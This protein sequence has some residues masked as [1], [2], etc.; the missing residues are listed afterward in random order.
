MVSYLLKYQ[1]VLIGTLALIGLLG[2][3]VL[4]SAAGGS[5]EPW[6]R[7]HLVR[8][9]VCFCAMLVLGALPIEWITR[10]AWPAYGV[11]LG[12]LVY[13]EVFGTTGKG[14]VVRWIDFGV[15]NLQPSELMKVALVLV[16]A[17]WY[18][19]RDIDRISQIRELVLP[20]LV[21]LL[22]VGLVLKQPD[23]GTGVIL[24]MT[25]ATMLF[26]A[27]VS[28]YWFAGGGLACAA[29]LPLGWFILK[30]YQKERILAFLNPDK[31]ALG[32]GYHIVQSKIALGSGGLNGKGFL[33]GTQSHLNFL[34]EKHTDFIFATLAEEFGLIGSLLTVALVVLAIGLAFR[35]GLTSR[36][37]FGRL[38]AS[39]V[40]A[41]LF[42]YC[43]VNM[44]MV[45]SLMPVVGVPFPLVS[46]GGSAMMTIMVG[47]GLVLCV[48][49]HK[50]QW[51]SRLGHAETPPFR[52]LLRRI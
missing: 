26:L 7:V 49:R 25:G 14:S 44:G 37:H 19:S 33:Q 40:G 15:I 6:A 27:G 18:H 34:P 11:T 52:G 36:H 45:M 29:A 39:G 51:L 50:S 32:A 43:F 1:W 47:F 48:Y 17:R 22:P 20:I 8:F 3:A 46:Y 10:L 2:T 31:D 12:M 4:Y 42:F 16:L 41:T 35:T 28:R 13:I 9:V 38:L 23:L 5:W 30:P 21:I 24:L